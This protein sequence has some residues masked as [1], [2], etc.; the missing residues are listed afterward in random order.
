M[1]KLIAL[2]TPPEN[3][4]EFDKHYDEVHSPLMQKVP[5]LERLE[6]IRNP[7]TFGGDSPYYLI[8]EMYFAD[9]DTLCHV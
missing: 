6:V 5:G 7:R 4:E 9:V 2:F 3:V 8:A 1:Y